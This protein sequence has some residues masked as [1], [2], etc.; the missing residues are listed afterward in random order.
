MASIQ[1]AAVGSADI[2]L[3]GSP[4]VTHFRSLYK[5]HVQFAQESIEN[6]FQGPADFGT[7][8]T[9]TLQKA[10]DL[11]GATWLQ[12]QL[13]DLSLYT[14]FT[15][16]AS[17][18]TAA[19]IRQAYH[20]SK[21]AANVVVYPPTTGGTWTYATATLANSA[22]VASS[23]AP[24]VNSVWASSANTANVSLTA[25]SSAD[26]ANIAHYVAQVVYGSSSGFVAGS[27]FTGNPSTQNITMGNSNYT[28]T[29]GNTYGA[30]VWGVYGNSALTTKSDTIYWSA[31]VANTS[32]S[33]TNVQLTGLPWGGNTTAWSATAVSSTDTANSSAGTSQI[34][35]NVK[36]TNNIGTALL[37][38]LEFE[39][40]GTRIERH[41]SPWYDV[42]Q[43]LTETAEK[44]VGMDSMLLNYDSSYDIW[45]FSNSSSA[46]ALLFIPVRFV[47][48]RYPSMSLPLVALQYHDVRINFEFANYLACINSS[49]SITSLTPTPS[50]S[51]IRCFVDYFMLE[52]SERVRFASN[53]AEYL[54]ENI[55]YQ[56]AEQLLGSD[57]PSGV[58]L[59]RKI[60]LNFT[61][62]V[63]ELMWVYQTYA[64]YQQNPYT[65][66]KWFDYD[67]LGSPD[68]EPFTAAQLY[69]NGHARFAARPG[70]YFRQVV[71]YQT[72]TRVP[73]KKV[74]VWSAA[75]N[76]EDALMPSGAFNAS[77]LDNIQLDLTIDPSVLTGQILVWANTLNVLRIASGMG[78]LVFASG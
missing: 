61:Q 60:T 49:Q 66:N 22:T 69:F 3:T 53:P 59:N 32:N 16:Q 26:T 29:A 4:Q 8:S 47:W 34:V 46:A 36:W 38:A 43:Q 13:P 67:V 20:G 72:H 51:S 31:A 1:L 45:D 27:S 11:A 25:P 68:L 78:G 65:G 40:G 44:K 77:R 41:T 33:L 17:Q 2:F 35:Q 58:V 54:V 63:K 18:T 19:T 14:V 62:P 9:I 24:T 30:Q 64:N 23:S 15:P 42:R 71:P 10:G 21:F 7:R 50:L 56:G 74:Y 28:L 70:Q 12:V 76:P 39:I 52:Q 37:S 6:V 5:R 75:L 48:N 73:N 55:Q 57:S